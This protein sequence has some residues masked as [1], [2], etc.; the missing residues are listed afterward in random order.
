MCIWLTESS[1]CASE[2]LE[3]NYTS[4]IYL[5]ILKKESELNW[6]TRVCSPSDA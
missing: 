3:V 4:I 6:I 5:Y 2:T 1:C